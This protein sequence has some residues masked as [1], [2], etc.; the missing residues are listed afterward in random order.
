MVARTNK[1]QPRYSILDD[2]D[3]A[4]LLFTTVRYWMC[5]LETI[6]A[7]SPYYNLPVGILTSIGASLILGSHLGRCSCQPV[8]LRQ[9]A[10]EGATANSLRTLQVAITRWQTQEPSCL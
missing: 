7:M 10:L 4:L 2:G 9:N 8:A 1:R 6:L 5:V 3:A